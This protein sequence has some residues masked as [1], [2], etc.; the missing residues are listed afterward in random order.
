MGKTEQVD[1]IFCLAINFH[2]KQKSKQLISNV[3]HI[4]KSK[5]IIDQI[6]NTT[7]INKLKSVIEH[8]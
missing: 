7:N 8:L 1:I 6:R 3:Y 2:D 5:D 4:I